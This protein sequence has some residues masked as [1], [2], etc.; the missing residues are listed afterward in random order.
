MVAGIGRSR[1]DASDAERSS[2]EY[3]GFLEY[4]ARRSSAT[5]AL[6]KR[7][8]HADALIDR[9][10]SYADAI[11]SN[12]SIS[13]FGIGRRYAGSQRGPSSNDVGRKYPSTDTLVDAEF[14][15]RQ[16]SG[17]L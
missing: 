10:S 17:Q 4:G 11:G 1:S 5:T 12:A 7:R 16:A 2:A 3:D 6:A 8:G 9:G 13:G 14:N 15:H